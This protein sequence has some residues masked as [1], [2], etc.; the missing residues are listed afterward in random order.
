MKLV[1][2]VQFELLIAG[3]GQCR[4]VICR[5]LEVFIVRM[6]AEFPAIKRT[7]AIFPVNRTTVFTIY[8]C[9]YLGS[10]LKGIQLGSLECLDGIVEVRDGRSFSVLLEKISVIELM[11]SSALC[12]EECVAP[13]S[14]CVELGIWCCSL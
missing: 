11:T 14:C 3:L 5:N 8:F 7:F 10:E 9:L 6:I 13:A 1:V 2:V 12:T 4:K